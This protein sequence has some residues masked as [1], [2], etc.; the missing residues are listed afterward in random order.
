VVGASLLAAG[1]GGRV[2]R[3]ALL[4]AAGSA[5][6]L[7][8]VDVVHALRGRISRVYLLDA[9]LEAALVGAWLGAASAQ[10]RQPGVR[11]DGSGQSDH[12]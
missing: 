10:R 9:V 11:P 5:T 3:P 12:S 8:G 2:E 4:L 7:G 6:A 1:R